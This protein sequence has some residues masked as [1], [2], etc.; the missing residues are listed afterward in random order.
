[1][2]F[3]EKLAK[4]E[5]ALDKKEKAIAKVNSASWEEKKKT[6]KKKKKEEENV[7]VLDLNE[8]NK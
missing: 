5:K 2:D 1:M 7:E 6:K 3:L 8:L 4:I